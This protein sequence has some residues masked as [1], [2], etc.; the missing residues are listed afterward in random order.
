[1]STE[2]VNRREASQVSISLR[3][4][5]LSTIVVTLFL[6]VTSAN[7]FAQYASAPVSGAAVVTNGKFTN[8]Y[9]YPDPDKETW[10]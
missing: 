10:D 2:I 6:L 4:S 7:M 9:F 5:R 1:M 3:R 8:I